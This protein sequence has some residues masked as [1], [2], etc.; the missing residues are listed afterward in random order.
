MH[1]LKSVYSKRGKHF[2][3]KRTRKRIHNAVIWNFVW[4]GAQVI[5]LMACCNLRLRCTLHTTSTW[6]RVKCGYG[7]Q[8][9]RPQMIVQEIWNVKRRRSRSAAP[10]SKCGNAR[11]NVKIR[12]TDVAR[13]GIGKAKGGLASHRRARGTNRHRSRLWRW[14]GQDSSFWRGIYH[15]FVEIT[16]RDLQK[17]NISNSRNSN[18]QNFI[19]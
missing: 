19:S 17:L 18:S 16:I 11:R 8:S 1:S 15:H 9:A 10:Q 6:V 13:S 2:P 14:R 5:V 12:L 7:W 4:I 3:T